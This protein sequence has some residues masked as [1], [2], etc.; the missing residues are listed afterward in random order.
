LVFIRPDAA[1][2]PLL[3]LLDLVTKAER[4]LG[5][6]ADQPAWRPR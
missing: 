1:K 3:H 4:T 6:P 2:L 5:G